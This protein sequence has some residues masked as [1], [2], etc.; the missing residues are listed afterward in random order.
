MKLIPVLILLTSCM[1][2]APETFR[3][4]YVLTCADYGVLVTH[5]SAGVVMVAAG[6]SWDKV[7]E[8][9]ARDYEVRGCMIAHNGMLRLYWVEGDSYA[10]MHEK[11][12][13]MN[14]RGHV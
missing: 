12:H 8:L 3:R 9:C 11:C 13:A 10:E 1:T 7:N 2:Y 4:D 5:E 14:G 6:L